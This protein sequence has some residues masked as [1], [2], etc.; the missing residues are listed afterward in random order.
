[1]LLLLNNSTFR[2]VYKGIGK[3]ANLT[4]DSITKGYQVNFKSICYDEGAAANSLSSA[5]TLT[6][7]FIPPVTEE[8]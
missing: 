3:P 7:T 5:T 2:L 6:T 8:T 1:M 4:N